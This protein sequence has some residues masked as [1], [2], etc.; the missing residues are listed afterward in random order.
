MPINYQKVYE[1]LS[2]EEKVSFRDLTIKVLL[3]LYPHY[4]VRPL[5]PQNAEAIFIG[6]KQDNVRV[7][8]P[9][10]DL[11]ARFSPSSQTKEDLKDAILLGYADML[12]MVEDAEYIVDDEDMT[13]SD[14]KKL[15]QPR[16]SRLDHVEKFGDHVHY[17]FGEEIVTGFVID[18][19]DENLI[20]HIRAPRLEKWNI[21]QEDLMKQAMEN[22]AH[23]A[24]GI[25]FWGTESPRGYLRTNS[26]E[27]YSAT[28]ILIGGV[29]HLVAQ[30]IG[31]PYR[32]GIP[33][34]YV[35]YAWVELEDQEFQ[36][37]MKAMME[38][39]FLRLPS[40]LTTNIYEVDEQGQMKQLKNQPEVPDTPMFG[41]N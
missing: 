17:P 25:E 6:N 39:E 33:S 8:F 15:V 30:T 36:K 11:Y 27:E 16:F 32:F 19:P 7:T 12:K 23:A 5:E 31:V 34:S 22:F 37:E 14:A 35:F 2:Y 3:E 4:V 13:W 29:R 9:L 24:S 38:R 28:T 40:K 41:N 1:N 18:Y 26:K 21:S 10:H 20:T